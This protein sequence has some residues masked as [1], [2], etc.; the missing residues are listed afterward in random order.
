MGGVWCFILGMHPVLC[1]GLTPALQRTLEFDHLVSGEVNRAREVHLSAAGKGVNVALVLRQLGTPAQ[2]TGFIGGANGRHLIELLEAQ[3]VESDFTPMEAE[4][5][6]CQTLLDL[7]AG[8]TTE[9]V[10]E[11]PNPPPETWDRFFLELE[12]QLPNM[13][14]AAASGKLPPGADDSVYARMARAARTVGIPFLL[15]SWGGPLLAALPERPALVKMSLSELAGTLDCPGLAVADLPDAAAVLLKQGAERVLVTAGP[16]AAWFLDPQQAV[17]Y[18]PPRVPAR[19][20]IGSGDS[21]TAGIAH[22]L[23]AGLDWADAV[24]LGIACGT[25]NALTLL[26]GQL[27]ADWSALIEHVER[28]TQ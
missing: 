3:G 8:T 10:E 19:N 7:Q 2:V 1:I 17:R 23:L 5:R 25:A 24:R 13:G 26:P 4:T 18:V 11:A 22:G 20:P 12:T 27:D 14:L 15:D 28:T 16:D 9:L 21:V 6:I